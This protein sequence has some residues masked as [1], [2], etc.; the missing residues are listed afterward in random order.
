[1]YP[2][3]V[4]TFHES[5]A[6]ITTAVVSLSPFEGEVT[7]SLRTR[8]YREAEHLVRILD[9]EF[10]RFFESEPGMADV[11]AILRER[12]QMALEADLEQHLRTPARPAC[13]RDAHWPL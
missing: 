12:L 6:S 13:L 3:I 9:F 1:M 5:A 2:H 11:K 8:S 7:L 10:N 4:P